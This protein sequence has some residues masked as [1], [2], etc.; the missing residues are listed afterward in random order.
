MAWIWSKMLAS[1]CAILRIMYALQ[2]DLLNS[3]HDLFN[4]TSMEAF[5]KFA[6]NVLECE[7]HGHMLRSGVQFAI[8]RRCFSA[9]TEKVEKVVDVTKM[10]EMELM[11]M[12]LQS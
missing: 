2:Q 10:F 12:S 6:E 1:Y 9:C 7:R 3:D 4:V 8:W 5:C 11:P